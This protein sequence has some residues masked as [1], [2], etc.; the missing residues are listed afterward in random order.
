MCT[1]KEVFHWIQ[2]RTKADDVVNMRFL[3]PDH[4]EPSN[5]DLKS[6]QFAIRNGIDDDNVYDHMFESHSITENPYL[7]R[8]TSVDCNT[9]GFM[10]EGN[11][12]KPLCSYS[13]DTGDLAKPD[14]EW[15]DKAKI[16]VCCNIDNISTTT[17]PFQTIILELEIST[18]V[19]ALQVFGHYNTA[20]SC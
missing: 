10:C 8:H 18:P 3:S 19:N 14:K 7:Y 17:H 1:Y 13:G 12:I 9:K 5:Q 16:V 2:R 20:S 15:G 4:G 11:H 6:W